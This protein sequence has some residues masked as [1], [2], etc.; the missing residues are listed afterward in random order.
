MGAGM[1]DSC[2][3][4]KEGVEFGKKGEEHNLMPQASL[5]DALG[6]YSLSP[7]ER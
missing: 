6:A 7:I 4:E 2:D 1:R 3:W 5:G